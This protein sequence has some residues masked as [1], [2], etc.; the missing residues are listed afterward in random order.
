MNKS[1]HS[2]FS[3]GHNFSLPIAGYIRLRLF[4]LALFLY[5]EQILQIGKVTLQHD[6]SSL[7]GQ[8]RL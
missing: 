2:S 1:T 7:R 5:R 4:P 3:N 6:S 8:G